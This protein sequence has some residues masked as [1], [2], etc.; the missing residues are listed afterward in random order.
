MSCSADF[1]SHQKCAP[2][3]LFTRTDHSAPPHKVDA[4]QIHGK[5]VKCPEEMSVHECTKTSDITCMHICTQCNNQRARMFY[6]A[7]VRYLRPGYDS[8][9]VTCYEMKYTP[10]D[11]K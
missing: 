1:A 8:G 4:S 6:P 5:L 10:V 11:H 2:E 3:Q 9:L 7:Y